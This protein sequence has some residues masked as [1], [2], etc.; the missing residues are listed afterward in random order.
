MCGNHTPRHT[1][2]LDDHQSA[3]GRW[4]PPALGGQQLRNKRNFAVQRREQVLDI[5]EHRLDLD[6]Q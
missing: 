5:E 4:L 2:V 6:D 1:P 3:N